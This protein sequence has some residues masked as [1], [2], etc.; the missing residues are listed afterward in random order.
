MQPSWTSWVGFVFLAALILVT[1]CNAWY[2]DSAP[3]AA[4]EKG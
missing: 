3:P 4:V 2:A 1:S